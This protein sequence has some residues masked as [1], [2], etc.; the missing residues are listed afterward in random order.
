MNRPGLTRRQVLAGAGATIAGL[1]SNFTGA[2]SAKADTPQRGGKFVYV[3]LYPNN[4]AGDDRTGRHPYHLLDLNTR[5]IYN[6]LAWVDEQLEVQPELA[7]RWEANADQTIWDV[8]L[9]EGV[10]FHDGRDMTADDVVAS[11]QFHQANTSFAK[12]IVKI[13]KTG[14]HRVRMRLD[15]SNS[16]FPYIMGEY[17]LMIMPAAALDVIGY[18]GV[19]TGPF[20]IAS[21]DAK[22]RI[23]AERNENYWRPGMPYVDTLEIVASPGRME[24]ALNGFQAGVFDAILGVDPGMV[25]EL[26][27]MRDVQIDMSDAGDQ[28]LMIL[29]KYEGSV[30]NDK[31][32]RQALAFAIDRE[33]V[34][35]IV[36]GKRAGWVGNDSHLAPVNSAFLPRKVKR[37]VAKAKALLAEAGYPKGITLPIFYFAASWPEIPRVFQVIAE[38]V[39]EAGITLPIE[40]RPT[41]GYREWRV[42]DREKTRKHKFAYG[43]SGVR[44]PAVSLYRMRP[45]NNESGYWSGPSC[46]EYM[47]L[48]KQAAAQQDGALRKALYVRMQE[49]LHDDVPAILPSGRKNVLINR[50]NVRGLRNHSQWWSIRFDEVWKHSASKNSSR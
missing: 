44:N 6:G 37:D 31:R 28:A 45:D 35:K 48:Y 50:P 36:Y 19:G 5:S 13:E 24:S 39:K 25:P 1:S 21:L 43:P 33:R 32:I 47:D 27:S 26:R 9:R 29:P 40:Q 7:T 49:I 17:Q 4:R 22:R 20:R 8:E 18:S 42:E 2:W 34:E 23:V 11:Y 14:N 38:T 10:R 16:E 41:N 30:F 3:N 15:A 12:Q 46:D